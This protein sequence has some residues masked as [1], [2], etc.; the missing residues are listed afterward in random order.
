MKKLLIATHNKAKVHELTKYLSDIP[1]TL[2]TLDDVGIAK[3]VEEAGKTFEENA[4]LKAKFYSEKSG[5]PALADDGGIEIDA[6]G[7]MPGV[8]S[9]R[10]AGSDTSDQA[11]IDH[12]LR[13]MKDIPLKDR[14]AQMHLVLALFFPDGTTKTAEGILRGIIAKKQ[15]PDA[16]MNGFPYRALFYLPEIQKYYNQIDMS[17]DEEERYNHR[18]KAVRKIRKY[19][20]K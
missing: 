12:T 5:L 4:I 17:I 14:G 9:K 18:R 16:Q 20:M 13:E 10:W 3:D 15:H 1:Y 8:H 6:L 11:I 19:L 7:G 2:V